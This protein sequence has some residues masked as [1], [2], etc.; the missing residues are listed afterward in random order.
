M[1]DFI[2]IDIVGAKELAAKLDKL[3]GAVA[4]E[5]VEYAN[6]QVIKVMETYAPY[7]YIARSRVGWAS[8]KQRRYVMMK[9]SK[10]EMS[11]PYR[12]TQRQRGGWKPVGTG[13]N[14]IVVNE[15]PSTIYTMGDMTQAL[16]HRL[17]GWETV[18]VRL[19]KHMNGIIGKFDEGVRKAI[20]ILGL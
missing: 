10:G 6:K 13:T 17:M 20:K 11:V 8:E 14:Q 2:G 12:R 15:Q 3:P 4:D 19:Q 9:I 1:S 5:G 16:R 18:S 7:K